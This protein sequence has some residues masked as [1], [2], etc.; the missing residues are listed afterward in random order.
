[1]KIFFSTWYGFE[2]HAG[3]HLLPESLGYPEKGGKVLGEFDYDVSFQ[4]YYVKSKNMAKKIG[5]FKVLVQGVRNT[6]SY[7]KSNGIELKQGT[8]YDISKLLISE[9]VVTIPNNIDYYKAIAILFDVKKAR[10]YLRSI[11]DISYY[12][13]N[14]RIYSKWSGFDGV[15]FRDSSSGQAIIKNGYKIAIG[16]YELKGNINILLDDLGDSFEPFEFR[17]HKLDKIPKDIN[18]LIGKNGLGKTHILKNICDIITGLRASSRKPLFNKLI[19]V[20]YSPFETFYTKR[21][22]ES[23]MS[24]IYGDKRERN[25]GSAPLA[26]DD[27]SYIGFRN[28]DG[29]F[30]KDWPKV[31]SAK[32][33]SEAI[34][35]DNDIAWR[36]NQGEGKF[37]SIISTLAL[38][39]SFDTIRFRTING[40][41][42]DVTPSEINEI[43]LDENDE[44]NFQEGV[45]YLKGN[46]EVKMSSGQQIFSY[47]IPSIIAE[48][49]DESLIIIDEP[50]LYL[51]PALEVGLIDMLKRV[52]NLTKSYAVI[53]THSAV[54]AR[55]V[56][57]SCVKVLK[58]ATYGTSIDKPSIETYGESLD[59]IIGEVFG[60]YALKKPYQ[61][62]ID[63]LMNY[64]KDF[65]KTLKD[66][67]KKIGDEGLVYLMSRFDSNDEDFFGDKK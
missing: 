42:I 11:C 5:D 57:S 47:M 58:E 30:E 3:V 28:L 46:K 37:N 18:L 39:M 7:F 59:E 17:F 40:S 20:S 43:D 66:I 53:A 1:M 23:L 50:E 62:E 38:S 54:L 13:N 21:E 26:I 56:Q 29:D 8:I 9:K 35:Y 31:F 64:S 36:S 34:K 65:N 14:Y 63:E 19:V 4:V 48:I 60:D 24:E 61:Y 52:L 41:N 32:S 6:S 33:F 15:V 27:Y 45:A 12:K 44:I 10:D 25:S 67:S 22:L 2:D 51:H 55:E 16:S 49:Q